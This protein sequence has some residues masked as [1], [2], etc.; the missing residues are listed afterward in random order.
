MSDL[1]LY[2]FESCPYC[3]R[4]L[5]YLE[6]KDIKIELKNIHQDQEAASELVEIGG[7]DQVPCLF[8]DGEPLYESR[9]IINWLK[10]NC[11]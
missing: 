3:K 9:D 7:R 6:G 2:Y 4:V 8:I 11:E 5:N 1:V 10:E